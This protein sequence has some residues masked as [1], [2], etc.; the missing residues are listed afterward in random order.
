MVQYRH[1]GY[2]T[3]VYHTSSG[4]CLYNRSERVLLPECNITND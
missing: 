2:A 1:I 3:P 4:T